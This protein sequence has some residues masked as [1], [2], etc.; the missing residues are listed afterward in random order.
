MVENWIL[1]LRE[2]SG[3]AASTINRALNCLKVMFKEAV[4]RGHLSSS[5]VQYWSSPDF[6]WTPEYA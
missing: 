1:E 3:L 6:G 4:K 2:I 5:P